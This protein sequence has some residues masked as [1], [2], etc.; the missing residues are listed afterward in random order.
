MS[1]LSVGTY[2]GCFLL[3]IA[4][5]KKKAKENSASTSPFI[6]TEPSWRAQQHLLRR[7]I[8]QTSH[9]LGHSTALCQQTSLSFWES[10]PSSSIMDFVRSRMWL[11]PSQTVKPRSNGCSDGDLL[12]AHQ[13]WGL[14][15]RRRGRKTEESS[16]Y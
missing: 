8:F 3:H 5:K 13:H 7:V 2:T 16:E 14:M 4:L 6:E 10:V 1:I 9:Y 15:V 12:P 11:L